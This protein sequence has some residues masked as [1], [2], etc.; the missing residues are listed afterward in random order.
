MKRSAGTGVKLGA[1][2][3]VQLQLVICT[4]LVMS[5]YKLLPASLP[6]AQNTVSCMLLRFRQCQILHLSAESKRQA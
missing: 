2:W 5:N 4:T 1:C 6:E 3:H